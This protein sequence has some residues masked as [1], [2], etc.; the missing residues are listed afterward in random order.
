MTLVLTPELRALALEHV[1][2]VL[3]GEFNRLG[4]AFRDAPDGMLL[5][6]DYRIEADMI[7]VIAQALRERAYQS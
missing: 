6:S 4:Y 1:I 2:T 7:V 3:P 5:R